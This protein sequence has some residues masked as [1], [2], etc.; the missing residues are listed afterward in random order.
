[1][2]LGRRPT[3]LMV[4]SPIEAAGS[5]LP[6]HRR[7]AGQILQRAH[8][9]PV[10]LNRCPFARARRAAATPAIELLDLREPAVWCCAAGRRRGFRFSGIVGGRFGATMELGRRPTLLMV[11]SPIEAAG[12]ELPGH[13]RNAGQ[14]LQRAHRSPFTL[15]AALSRARGE[16]R[17]HRRSSCSTCASRRCG[18]A[19]RAAPGF[20][21]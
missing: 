21:V 19:P 14:I 13:R 12:S 18:A 5:E 10:H 2:E 16:R 17:Q 20:P 15:I 6:G 4:A 9:S 1:M 3:L 11:A 8:K 7:N